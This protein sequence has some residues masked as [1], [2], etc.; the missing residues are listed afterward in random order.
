[1]KK[2]I[3]MV[4]AVI[5]VLAIILGVYLFSKNSIGGDFK[6]DNNYV[7][8]EKDILGIDLKDYVVESY[9]IDF[10]N[11]EYIITKF[12]IDASQKD[13]LISL[14][15]NNFGTYE[16]DYAKNL[17]TELGKRV[18]KDTSGMDVIKCY[19]KFVSGKKVKTRD[20]HAFICQKGSEYYLF[21]YG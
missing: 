21:I 6:L 18:Q 10:P 5:L 15:D 3:S 14:L 20:I 19:Q 2:R 7:T 17:D 1:M 13:S 8:I 9:G 12:K 16:E 4:F 11:E